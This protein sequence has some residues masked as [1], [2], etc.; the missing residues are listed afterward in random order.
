MFIVQHRKL[1][2]I[3]SGLIIAASIV[4]LAVWGL[5]PGIDFKGGSLIE[6]SY[7][8]GRP[9]KAV[10]ER[11]LQPLAVDASVRPTG[12]QGFII[13]MKDLIDEERTAVTV[14]VTLGSTTSATI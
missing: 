9:E 7:P 3:L 10:I 2:Y 8:S 13:R 14:A 12:E 1:F 11:V 6:V 4:A 5:K